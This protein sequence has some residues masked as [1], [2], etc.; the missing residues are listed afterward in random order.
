[1]ATITTI[2]QNVMKATGY[3]PPSTF[4]GSN[5]PDARRMVA[6]VNQAGRQL[7]KMPWRR[8]TFETTVSVSSTAIYSLPTDFSEVVSNTLWN[9]SENEEAFGPATEQRWQYNKGVGAVTYLTPEWRITPDKELEVIEPPE[10]TQVFVMEYRSDHW[11]VD[12]SSSATADLWSAETERT[13]L[14]EGVFE[15]D[16]TWRWLRAKGMDYQT[17]YM[18]FRR[19]LDD[20]I[21]RDKGGAKKL[22]LGGNL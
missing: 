2:C 1:M 8:L 15:L 7:S 16:L 14:E 9:R 19:F 5:A 20:E 6:I 3:T 18:E 22:S 12:T 13:R 17:E 11:V 10:D 4:I 21:C